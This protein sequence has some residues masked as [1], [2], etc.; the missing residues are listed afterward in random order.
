MFKMAP[1]SFYTV[2]CSLPCVSGHFTNLFLV[3]VFHEVFNQRLQLWDSLGLA[4][5]DM[6]HRLSPDGKIQG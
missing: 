5:D 3:K 2:I 6:G 4:S 1:V